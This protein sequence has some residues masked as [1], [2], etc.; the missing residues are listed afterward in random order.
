MVAD[1][2][3]IVLDILEKEYFDKYSISFQFWGKNNNNAFIEKGSQ[4]TEL[5]EFTGRAS[6]LDILIDT[7]NYLDRINKKQR[8]TNPNF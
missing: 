5:I 4:S 6:V 2:M 3:G 8:K 1:L 7:L